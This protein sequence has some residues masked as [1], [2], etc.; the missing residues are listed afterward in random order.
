MSWTCDHW[1][2]RLD[3]FLDGGLAA[4]EQTTF[5]AHAAAC[6]RCGELLRLV[7]ADLPELGDPDALSSFDPAAPDLA[8]DV[9]A[10]TSG[11]ACGRAGN[12]LARRPD[13]SLIEREATLLD[14]HLAHCGDC[15]ALAR[16]LTWVLPMLVEL[17]EPELDPAFTYDVLRETVRS[18]ERKRSGAPGRLGDRIQSWWEGQVRRS[19]FVWE[20]AFAATV[21]LVLLCGTPLSPGREAPGKA[22][23]VVRAGPDWI[24]ERAGE[25]VGAVG[26]LIADLGDDIEV[27]RN[28]T[29]PDRSDIK[30]HGR[31][32]GSSLIKADFDSAGEDLE[33]VR[34]DFGKMWRTWRE[35]RPDSLDTT[36][37]R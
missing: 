33:T 19:L 6:A 11:A 12:L 22:L 1:D 36:P 21:A 10:A 29:A 4:P 27:R 7:S 20:I 8:T 5:L 31:D 24:L 15:R 14:G 17:A 18:R 35:S 34:E 37:Q 28:R 9:L 16:T 23:E 32:L 30:R 2:E 13:G 25:A 3:D 26:G